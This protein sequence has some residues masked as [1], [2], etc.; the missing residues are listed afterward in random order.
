MVTDDV[1]G[2]NCLKWR[3]KK[4]KEFV[5]LI[6]RKTGK[7]NKNEKQINQQQSTRSLAWKNKTT[8]IILLHLKLKK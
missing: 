7:G 8:L 1:V 4:K 3:R 6:K 5:K 2:C